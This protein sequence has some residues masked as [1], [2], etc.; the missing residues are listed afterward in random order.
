MASWGR[1]ENW[2]WLCI[3]VP[4]QSGDLCRQDW[5]CFL[6]GCQQLSAVNLSWSA[7]HFA[8]KIDHK[9]GMAA[10]NRWKILYLDYAESC[11]Q[12]VQ[13]AFKDGFYCI[14]VNNHRKLRNVTWQWFMRS[15]LCQIVKPLYNGWSFIYYTT[16]SLPNVVIPVRFI[17]FGVRF[18]EII[19]RSYC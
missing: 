10:Q 15:H 9:N 14:W 16:G 13:V 5:L 6:E 4:C 1:R 12:K 3:T 18:K 17:F 7:T 11:H 8:M 2:F 19:H